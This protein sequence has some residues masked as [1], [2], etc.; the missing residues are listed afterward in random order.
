MNYLT[1]VERSAENLQFYL[2]LRDYSKR[3]AALPRSE[4]VLSPEW[5]EKNPADTETRLGRRKAPK[6]LGPAVADV[7]KDSDLLQKPPLSP[8]PFNTPPPS[9]HGDDD[10]V[11]SIAEVSSGQFSSEP[12]S[13]LHSNAA[14]RE[15]AAEAFEGADR[16]QP[17]MFAKPNAHQSVLTFQSQFNP[18]EKK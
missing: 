7:L 3:F 5:H 16:F 11:S 8:N 10:S 4:G 14:A 12:V 15:L 1:Y 13:T 6:P 2:W 18:S 17:C 9:A